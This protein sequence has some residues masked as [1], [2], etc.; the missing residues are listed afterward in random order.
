MTRFVP[1]TTTITFGFCLIVALLFASCDQNSNLVSVGLND[2]PNEKLSTTVTLVEGRLV[3]QDVTS[4]SI[5]MEDIITSESGVHERMGITDNFVS[6][7]TSTLNL[8]DE[9]EFQNHYDFLDIEVVEDPFFAQA[10]N[11]HGEIQIEETVYKITRNYVYQ[12][13]ASDIK[14]IKNIDLR[15]ADQTAFLGSYSGIEGVSVHEIKRFDFGSEL[16]STAKTMAT[17]TCT[18]EFQSRR[19][20]QGISWITDFT[21]YIS[22]GVRTRAQRKSWFRWRSA[23]VEQ[24]SVTASYSLTN[25]FSRYTGG[26]TTGV[27]E[28]TDRGTASD[29]VKILMYDTG[30]V[31][32][33]RGTISASHSGVRIG[34][35]NQR[36]EARCYTRF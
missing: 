22:A 27:A 3:F 10:L 5:F 33:I 19:R 32:F 8:Q 30:P 2:P 36:Q 35:N 15:N 20:I 4:F 6:L 23:T 12:T 21:L 28:D 13:K 18:R 24:V 14:S 29:A 1:I 16:K 25:S 9:L 17:R 11:E 31:G 7:Y 34:K 26:P